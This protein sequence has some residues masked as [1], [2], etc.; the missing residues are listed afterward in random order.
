MIEFDILTLFPALCEGIFSVSMLGK[1]QE[2]RLIRVRCLDVRQ[3]ATGK[4]RVTDEPP[5]GGGPGMVMKVEPIFAAVE[6]I[7][8]PDSHVVLMSAAGERFTQQK[9]RELAQR[10]HLVFI[11]GHY[12]GVDQRVADHLANEELSIG[13]YILTNGAIAA[14][15]VVDAVARLVPGVLGESESM[16]DESFANGMLEYPQYTRPSVFRGWKVPD[17]LLSGNHAA[18]DTWRKQEAEKRTRQRAEA[19]EN[20]PERRR[21]SETDRQ[22]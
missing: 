11:C 7:R 19:S 4:H 5:Y 20:E 2:N 8:R 10:T 12:E 9:A 13:D 21:S 1:A 16:V 3:W 17:V 18:I 22:A 6:A 15:V 14:T